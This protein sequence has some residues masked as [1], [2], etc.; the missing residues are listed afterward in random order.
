MFPILTTVNYFAHPC[1]ILGGKSWVPPDRTKVWVS[2][3]LSGDFTC[4]FPLFNTSRDSVCYLFPPSYGWTEAERFTT[5]KISI[6]EPAFEPQ[7]GQSL[8]FSH[9]GVPSL[10][11][12][13]TGSQASPQWQT[14]PRVTPTESQP[15]VIPSSC[16]SVVPATG[17]LINK[18]RQWWW[19]FISWLLC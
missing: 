3:L 18:I 14:Q 19:D 1:S 16:V 4:S 9:R 12:W 6:L 2:A 15:C 11:V 10:R 17:L 8:A 7:C 5:F 13:W